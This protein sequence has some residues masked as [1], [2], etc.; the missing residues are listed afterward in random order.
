LFTR[1]F[2]EPCAA[3]NDFKTGRTTIS[4]FL[5]K[6]DLFS[7]RKSDVLQELRFIKENGLKVDPSNLSC[8]RIRREDW[9][10]S[11]KRH[12]KPMQIRGQL[13]IKPSWSQ[14][15][16]RRG[17]SVIVLDPGLSFGTGQHPTTAFCLGELVRF[18]ETHSTGAFLDAGTGSGIL[19]IAAAKLSFSPV[20]AFDFD[21]EALRIARTNAKTNRVAKRIHFFR[22]DARKFSRNRKYAFVCANLSTEVLVQA[23]RWITLSLQD[24]GRVVLA[25]ILSDEFAF[26]EK[27]AEQTGLR[28][29]RRRR[30]GEWTSG[31]FT[32]VKSM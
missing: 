13:L 12:F 30:V 20:D 18:A 9:A 27:L 3:Y 15:R 24:K 31:V 6:P 4:L 22:A 1:T 11:W 2:R 25:G 28:L 7:H 5:T 17:Q 23:L 8:R 21:S 32:N 16:A 14:R 10:E 19:A 26:L 29:V